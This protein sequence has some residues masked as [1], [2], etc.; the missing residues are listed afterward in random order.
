ME[1]AAP[2]AL[3]EFVE[4]AQLGTMIR[5]IVREEME[6]S[7]GRPAPAAA[8]SPSAPK[9]E[10]APEPTAA[11]V[12]ARDSGQSIIAAARS[13]GRWTEDDRMHFREAMAGL[14]DSGRAELLQTLLP[15]INRQ[16]IKLEFHGP[17]I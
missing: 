1:R 5:G 11:Q 2:P 4:R 16:E 13:A 7:A 8:A 17:P 12:T 14:D 15:A 9:A 3:Q 10:T 6:R